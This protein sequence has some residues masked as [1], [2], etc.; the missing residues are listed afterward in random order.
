MNLRQIEVL[1]AVI[2]CETTMGAARELAMSQP[3]V[4]NAIKH[5]ERQAGFALF[6]RVNNRLLPTADARTLFAESE[7]IFELH[8]TLNSRIQDMRERRTGHLRVISTP[9]LANAGL[10][11]GLRNFMAK[12]ADVRAHVDVGDARRVLDAVQ[13]GVSELGFVLASPRTPPSA[14]AQVLVHSNMVCVMPPQHA[15]ASRELVRPQDLAGFPFVALHRD[16][17]FGKAVR[18]SFLKVGETVDYL[19]ETRYCHTACLLVESGVGVSVVDPFSALAFR[20]TGMVVKRFEPQTPVTAYVVVSDR[21]PVSRLGGF[22]IDEMR[23]V[24]ESV[25][26]DVHA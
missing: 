10:P 22:F 15:L 3:A 23:R 18:Q 19:A 20:R 7:S 14:H 26:V 16:T 11:V 4:S 13:S 17:T 9:P 8:S 5:M 25:D 6:E 24:L 2:R 1:R 21:Q 12:H